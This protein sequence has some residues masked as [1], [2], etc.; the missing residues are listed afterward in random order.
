MDLGKNLRAVLVNTVDHLSQRLNVHRVKRIHLAGECNAVLLIDSEDL[1]D[2]Q[3]YAALC[4]VLIVLTKLFGGGTVQT[5]LSCSHGSHDSPVFQ[6]QRANM[7]F[8]K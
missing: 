8:F 5:G 2:D 4:A 3:A 6:G 1:C 7:T